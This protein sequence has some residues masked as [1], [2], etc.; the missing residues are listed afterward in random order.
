MSC[1]TVDIV[2][3]P[4]LSGC[5]YA[6]GITR[7]RAICYN[8]FV[9]W[10]EWRPGISNLPVLCKIELPGSYRLR[11]PNTN[12]GCCRDESQQ[13][14]ETMLHRYRFVGLCLLS[15]AVVMPSA[16]RSGARPQDDQGRGRGRDDRGQNNRRAYDPVHRD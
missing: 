16:V 10:A 15:A 6:I 4:E 3:A 13:E 7:C 1:H 11:H 12:T 2:N 14:S 8:D 5:T 9:D